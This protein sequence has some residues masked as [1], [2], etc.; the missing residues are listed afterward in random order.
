MPRISRPRPLASALL[1]DVAIL[2]PFCVR[3]CTSLTTYTYITTVSPTICTSTFFHLDG[4]L[5]SFGV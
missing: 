1:L 5:P 3:V 2:F 4:A